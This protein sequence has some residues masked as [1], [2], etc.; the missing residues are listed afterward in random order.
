MTTTQHKGKRGELLVLSE[1]TRRDADVYLPLIDTG[2]DAVV[3]QIDG[4]YVEI[5]VKSTEAPDQA[6]WFNVYDINVQANRFIV[7]VDMSRQPPEVWI[8]PSAEFVKY[9][10]VWTSSRHGWKRYTL[11]LD[12]KDRKHGNQ[13]RRVLL[14][15][16]RDAWHLL[17]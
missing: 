5:Q 17:A 11:G 7:C 10:T 9:S 6:G 15:S 3:R 14:G 8:L 2:I 16:Y 4:T 13:P 1:L 12:S